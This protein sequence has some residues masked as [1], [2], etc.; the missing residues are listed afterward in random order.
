M[1]GR[2]S[3]QIAEEL[4]YL[5]IYKL[6][7]TGMQPLSIQVQTVFAELAERVAAR[8]AGRTIARLSG[9]F[10]QKEVR[11]GRYWYFKTS[12]P[13]GGQ[14]EYYLGAETRTRNFR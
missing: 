11:D 12:I 3:R 2:K 6:G 7:I 8:E 9:F 4:L 14:H 5:Y 13:G 1:E 10:T